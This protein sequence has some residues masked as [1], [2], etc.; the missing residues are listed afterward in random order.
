[1][2]QQAIKPAEEMLDKLFRD[3]ERIPK[4][5]VQ[6]EAEEA[7]IAPDVMFYFNRL[8]DEELTRNQVV[9]NVN[10]MIKERHREQEIGLLH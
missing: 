8:P 5:V 1:M 3:K 7:R 4:E 10:N 2:G 9:Q 6:H